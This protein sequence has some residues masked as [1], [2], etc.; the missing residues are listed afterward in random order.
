V[1][2][3][4][5]IRS[6][7]DLYQY[8]QLVFRT[9]PRPFT[10]LRA[11]PRSILFPT[12]A[13]IEA[14][15]RF[16]EAAKQASGLKGLCPCHGLPWAAHFVKVGASG[17]RSGEAEERKPKLLEQRMMSLQQLPWLTRSLVRVGARAEK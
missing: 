14:R 12:D 7:E 16:S 10:Y 6:V 2:A 8:A 5:K 3:V 13:Q 11:A 1:G 15:L 4:K 17:F 9:R